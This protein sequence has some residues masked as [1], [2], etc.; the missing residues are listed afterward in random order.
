MLTGRSVVSTGF[1]LPRDADRRSAFPDIPSLA[2][3]SQP[4]PPQ[5][6]AT[7]PGRVRTWAPGRFTRTSIGTKPSKR[8]FGVKESK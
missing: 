7:Y 6:R 5:G 4:R 2:R 1:A 3:V 8:G